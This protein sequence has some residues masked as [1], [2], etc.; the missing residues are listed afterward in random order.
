M[1]ITKRRMESERAAAI[2]KEAEVRRALGPQLL[3]DAKHLIAAWNARA[4]PGP[5]LPM[6]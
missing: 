1:G 5:A 2:A 3:E 4:Y 6:N